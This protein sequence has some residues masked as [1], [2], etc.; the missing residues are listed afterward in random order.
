MYYAKIK[1]CLAEICRDK[2]TDTYSDKPSRNWTIETSQTTAI[3]QAA[4][5]HE[6][7][8]LVRVSFENLIFLF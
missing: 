4:I 7:L 1:Y 5:H 3:P 8:P 6:C 2:S